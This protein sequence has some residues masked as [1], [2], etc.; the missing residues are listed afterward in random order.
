MSLNSHSKSPSRRAL[1]LIPGTVNYFYNQSGRRVGEALE[2]LGFAVEVTTLGDL[3]PAEREVCILSNISEILHAHGNEEEGLERIRAIGARCRAMFSLG[4]DCVSTRWYQ[5]IRD[6]SAR[7]GAGT[8]LDLGLFDQSP[9]LA[10][11]HRASYRLVFSGLTPSELRALD[12][13]GE[14]DAA[15]TIPWA[16]VG[17]MTA[18]RVA[19][20]D[21]LVQRVDPRGF[22]YMPSPVPYPEKG[23][24]HLNQEQ[25]ERVLART[26]Y[27]IWCSGH[28]Y[29]Y[30]EPERFRTSLL[31]GGVPVKILESGLQTPEDVP[32]GYLMMDG[33]DVGGRLTEAAFARVRR[34]YRD[35]WR[36]FP[37][38]AAELARELQS[39][40]I[41]VEDK[42][43]AARA[44]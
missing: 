13:M 31:T 29:F 10:P 43:R 21:H 15:R 14:D 4:I 27:Q 18:Q 33:A 37:T 23:S 16:F 42:G 30:M 22:V 25:F 17:S 9:F 40:G 44:A 35:D 5:R 7:A 39:V 11:E 12:A 8:V 38:L 34:R 26:R 32:L 24:P 19:L 6:F 3:P 28:S 41:E 36:G 1:I 20:V 2:E